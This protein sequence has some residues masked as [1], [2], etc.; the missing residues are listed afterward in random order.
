MRVDTESGPRNPDPYSGSV[1]KSTSFGSIYIIVIGVLVLAL[2]LVL[3]AGGVWLMVLGGSWY[4]A[5]AGLGLVLSGALLTRENVFGVGVYLLVWIGTMIWAVW[6]VGFDMW[7]LVPRVVAPTIILVLVALTI[8][9]FAARPGSRKYISRHGRAY[10]P[11]AL[12]AAAGLAFT[13]MAQDPAAAQLPRLEAGAGAAQ[14]L[15]EEP[16]TSPVIGSG[17]H[18]CAATATGVGVIA[19]A[20]EI[21]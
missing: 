3:G 1:A 4:Y 19:C 18:R 7:P 11:L 17:G 14:A 15:H 6:E 12:L 16:H 2:G 10:Q 8:P 5:I 13:A 9:A 21:R 20:S